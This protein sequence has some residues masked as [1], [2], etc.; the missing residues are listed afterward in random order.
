MLY[1]LGKECDIDKTYY[2]KLV[3]DAV[4]AISEFG[5]FKWFVSDDIIP[6]VI[7]DETRKILAMIPPCGNSERATCLDCPDFTNDE[8]DI[9]CK[10]GYDISGMFKTN[11]NGEFIFD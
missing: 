7:P 9:D 2:T 10:K 4:D 6:D 1:T 5:D 8:F 11:E 3:D